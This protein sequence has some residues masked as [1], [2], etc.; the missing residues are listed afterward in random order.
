[1]LLNIGDD[2]ARPLKAL[3]TLASRD[4]VLKVVASFS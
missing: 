1:M 3:Q 4:D 2:K